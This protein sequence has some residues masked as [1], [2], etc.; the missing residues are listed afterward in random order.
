MSSDLPLT[1]YQLG[2][3]LGAADPGFAEVATVGPYVFYAGEDG[4]DGGDEDNPEIDVTE[5]GERN[6]SEGVGDHGK[7]NG[8]DGD[9]LE[10]GFEFTAGPS[11]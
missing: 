6:E 11:G 2:E 1:N 5:G 8:K 7:G 3:E 10:D 4:V 9:S